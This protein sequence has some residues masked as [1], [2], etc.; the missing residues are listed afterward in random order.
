MDHIAVVVA[1]GATVTVTD[2]SAIVIVMSLPV[3][4]IYRVP[5]PLPSVVGRAVKQLDNGQVIHPC[6]CGPCNIASVHRDQQCC[7][8]Q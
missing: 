6:R 5:G 7:A 1:R 2:E 4:V 3:V 8:K